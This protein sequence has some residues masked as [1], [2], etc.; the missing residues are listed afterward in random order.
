[1]I[2]LFFFECLIA[3]GPRRS[4]AAMIVT[5]ISMMTM[6]IIA[7]IFRNLLRKIEPSMARSVW[8]LFI[9]VV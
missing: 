5:T 6:I 9:R 1:M 2:F 4:T 8:F 3:Q 7:R